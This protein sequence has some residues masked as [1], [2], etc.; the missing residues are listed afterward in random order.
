MEGQDTISAGADAVFR[1]SLLVLTLAA[2]TDAAVAVIDAAQWAWWAAGAWGMVAL[3]LVGARPS[4]DGERA[5]RRERGRP[6]EVQPV[7][8]DAELAALVR[9]DW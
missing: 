4:P 5:A 3:L 1:C 9:R 6:Q 7:A 8:G 2:A